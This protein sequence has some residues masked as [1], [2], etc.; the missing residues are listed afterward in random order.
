MGVSDRE[1]VTIPAGAFGP[2]RASGTSRP[3]ISARSGIEDVLLTNTTLGQPL[4]QFF[5][6]R[7]AIHVAADERRGTEAELKKAEDEVILG[8]HQLYYGLL[9]ARKQTEV[10]HAEIAAWEQTLREAQDAVDAGDTLEVAVVGAHANLLS[11]KQALLAAEN[12]VVGSH[13]R[14]GRRARPAA[15]YGVG[16]GR[17]GPGARRPTFPPTVHGRGARAE[18]GGAGRQGNRRAKARDG[19]RAARY[20]Y[21]PDLSTA[22]STQA[23]SCATS[24]LKSSF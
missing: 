5:K 10:A 1:L 12:R 4:T 16:F 24:P 7:A 18:S 19:L 21:I 8:I 6:I 2:C 20:E 11:G 13:R 15:R 14:D 23:I 22:T 17:R 3:S 9:A